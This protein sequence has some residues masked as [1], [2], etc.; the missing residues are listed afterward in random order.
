MKRITYTVF[1]NMVP[2]LGIQFTPKILINQ[3]EKR[4]SLF[5]FI[6][7]LVYFKPVLYDISTLLFVTTEY[8]HCVERERR[9]KNAKWF[10]LHVFLLHACR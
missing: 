5:G 3:T 10:L 4:T 7:K 8:D 6:F 1:A 9:E 2:R